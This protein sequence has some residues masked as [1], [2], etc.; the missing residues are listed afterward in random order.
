LFGFETVS[1]LQGKENL[2]AL[3]NFALLTGARLMPLGL[4]SNTRGLFEIERH[5]SSRVKCPDQ[6][7]QAMIDRRIKAIFLAGPYEL[8][9]K[10][11]PEFLVVQDC[12]MNEIAERADVVLPSAAFAES[13]GTFINMEGR[14]QKSGKIIDSPGNAKPDWWIVS[15]IAQR[16][17]SQDFSYKKSSDIIKE[18]RKKIPT[19]VQVTYPSLEKGKEIFLKEPK[20]GEKTYILQRLKA[21]VDESGK[22]Y[23]FRLVLNY[24]LDHFKS[25]VL[26]EAIRGF[27]VFRDAQWIRICPED[28]GKLNLE[29]GDKLEVISPYGKI[30]GIARVSSAV[31]PGTAIASLK[32][33][34]FYN[35]TCLN[36]LPVKIKRGKE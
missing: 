24:N 35:N 20:A 13:E 32:N 3:W 21:Q 22:K 19:F 23:P 18:I 17:G 16:M 30:K 6:W 36:V 26:S 25:L 11:K 4:E 9:K 15:Q 7:D 8:P 2:A 27:G 5:F 31:R 1:G 34:W 33:P 29:S 14:V 28:A 12:F 10:A